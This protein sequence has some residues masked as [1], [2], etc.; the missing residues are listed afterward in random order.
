MLCAIGRRHGAQDITHARD[1][2]GL[3]PVTVAKQDQARF[4]G[5]SEREQARIV[6]IGRH[7]CPP[8]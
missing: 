2:I 4:G 6:K 3:A 8:L 5:P 1:Y 7:N